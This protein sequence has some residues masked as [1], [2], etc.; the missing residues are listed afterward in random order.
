MKPVLFFVLAFGFVRNVPANEGDDTL[1]FYMSKCVSIVSGT[2]VSDPVGIS[3]GGRSNYLCDF[4]ISETLHGAE[5][6]DHNIP[7]AVADILKG[8][9]LPGFISKDSKCI[10]FLMPPAKDDPGVGTWRIADPWFGV[11]PFS[12]KLRLSVQKLSKQAPLQAEPMPGA[13]RDYGQKQR[14]M[15]NVTEVKIEEFEDNE[16]LKLYPDAGIRSFHVVSTLDPKHAEL[17]GMPSEAKRLYAHEDSERH[18]AAF[19]REDMLA[20]ARLASLRLDTKERRKWFAR[21]V[22]GPVI[23]AVKEQK[24]GSWLIH[25]G[26]SGRVGGGTTLLTL[27]EKEIPVGVRALPD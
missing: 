15:P 13:V 18:Y 1:R 16:L 17:S 19:D 26:Y 22:S 27:D 2:I 25:W 7:L 3:E 10:V 20:L 24:K 9:K 14:A 6:P 4:K 5:Q 23:L 21:Q 11:Q 12:Q 8:D